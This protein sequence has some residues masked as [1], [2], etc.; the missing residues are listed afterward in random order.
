[1]I[2]IIS[3]EYG[4]IIQNF[5]ID[6]IYFFRIVQVKVIVYRFRVQRKY[7]SLICVKE[8][9]KIGWSLFEF[10]FELLEHAK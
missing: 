10:V 4:F 2:R 9:K 6:Y 3:A 8:T 5:Y 1:M 7:L